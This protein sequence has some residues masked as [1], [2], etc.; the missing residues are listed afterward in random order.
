MFNPAPVILLQ[1]CPATIFPG[2]H[3][4]VCRS[5]DGGVFP[6]DLKQSTITPII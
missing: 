2:L 5:F 6:E 4:I 1:S 3:Y